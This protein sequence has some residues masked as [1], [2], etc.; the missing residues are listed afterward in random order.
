MVVES[1]S[2][3]ERRPEPPDM[4][5]AIRY[6]HFG[7][8]LATRADI[9]ELRGEFNKGFAA[10]NKRLDSN[11]ARIDATNTRL[12]SNNE[13]IDA[14]NGRTDS[15]GER[16]DE[17]GARLDANGERLDE[18]GERLDA[19]NERLDEIN[20]R[21]GGLIEEVAALRGTVKRIGWILSALILISFAVNAA[22]MIFG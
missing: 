6:I 9:Q 4:S 12:D 19:N 16:L 11:N 5:D 8:G 21:L 17:N 7:M 1:Q 3:A 20:E 10:V 2:E 22:L 13:R 14:T 15:N 18:N